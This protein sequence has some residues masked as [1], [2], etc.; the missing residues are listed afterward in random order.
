MRASIIV[1]NFNTWEKLENCLASFYP[2]LSDQ[3]EIIIVDNH[4]REQNSSHI[5]NL[6]PRI[7][8]I[9][10]DKNLG[11]A[12][13]NNIGA[14]VANGEF[15][16]FLNP[17]TLI[18]NTT[19]DEMIAPFADPLVG[20][21]TSKIL[22]QN[23][24]TIIN[25]CGNNFHI[26]GI[27]Q[28]R[29]INQNL[30]DFNSESVVFAVSG[31][32]FSIR[33][34]LFIS[35]NGFD[36]DF[37][38]YMEDTDLSIR[39]RFLGYKCLFAPK[40]IVYHDYELRFGKNKIY[41]Q[42]KNRYLLFLKNFALKTLFLMIPVFFLSEIISWGFVLIRDNKS[43]KDKFRAY[44]WILTNWNEIRNKRNK[45]KMVSD[46]EILLLSEHAINFEQVEQSMVQK[47][48]AIVFNPIFYVLRKF[49][50]L[51]I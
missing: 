26:S 40:S 29:G 44:S 49:I 1:V 22:V 43:I 50:L 19:I 34:E 8:Y 36:P 6:F 25:A 12:G 27:T 11:Y 35:L 47:V 28:C 41:Y 5:I 21:T 48:A 18:T 46:K 30:S 51:F 37:F 17:D 10:S 31:A 24:P 15:L 9:Q 2:Y 39:A 4:S 38:L 14:K 16:I 20:L 23:E 33:K 7:N 42:E 3:D 13:G 45:S 32:A